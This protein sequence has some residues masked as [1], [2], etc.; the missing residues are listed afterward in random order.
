MKSTLAYTFHFLYWVWFI[1][2]LFYSIQEIITLKQVLVGE[3]LIFMVIST[4]VLF[5]VGLVLYLFTLTF[6]IP[7]EMNKQLRSV[8]LVLGVILIGLFFWA[9]NGN[10]SLR[11]QY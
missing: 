2:F 6:E 9:F 4:V 11:L 10:S 7:G 1:Y 3:G 8:S 5:F